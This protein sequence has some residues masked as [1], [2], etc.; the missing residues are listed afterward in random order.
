MRYAR[1][2]RILVLSLCVL[3]LASLALVGCGGGDEPNIT[4]PTIVDLPTTTTLTPVST[5]SIAQEQVQVPNLVGLDERLVLDQSGRIGL[6]CQMEHCDPTAAGSILHRAAAQYPAP[7]TWVSVHSTVRVI[8]ACPGHEVPDVVGMS[9]ADAIQAIMGCQLSPEVVY[10]VTPL[11]EDWG[12]VIAQDPA[13]DV[14]RTHWDPV[15]VDVGTEDTSAT[16][17]RTAPST[18]PTTV[19]TTLLTPFTTLPSIPPT[20]PPPPVS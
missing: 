8:L 19:T 14:L 11:R 6:N 16:T 12:N 3:A 5:P 1:R 7:G 2:L 10:V 15:Q 17:P 9:E 18:S 20:L 13:P 4:K